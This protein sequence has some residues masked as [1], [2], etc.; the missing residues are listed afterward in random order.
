MPFSTGS[1][2][3]KNVFPKERQIVRLRT[4]NGSN[5]QGIKIYSKC[6]KEMK[7]IFPKERQI[8]RLRTGNGSNRQCIKIYSKWSKRVSVRKENTAVTAKSSSRRM[9]RRSTDCTITSAPKCLRLCTLYSG[10]SVSICAMDKGTRQPS[11]NGRG[12]LLSR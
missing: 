4:G 7:D 8:F 1:K 10:H 5:R 2:E 9:W 3:M 6:T 12:M 11:Q